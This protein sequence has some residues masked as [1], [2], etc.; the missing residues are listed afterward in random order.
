MPAAVIA[1]A[2]NGLYTGVTG[3]GDDVGVQGHS[4]SGTGVTA[5]TSTGIAL[6]VTAETSS[7]TAL[8]V[9]GKA[10]FD[11][12]GESGQ[13]IILSPTSH[14]TVPS[15]PSGAASVKV[16]D[17]RITTKSFISVVFVSDPGNGTA[18]RAAV[19]YI[20]RATGSFTVFLSQKVTKKTNFA[21]F[22]VELCPPGVA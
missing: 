13:T 16:L 15:I 4:D 19:S 12:G 9:V 22:F 2:T 10:C 14:F 17:P 20:A 18:G 6:Q 3:V 5:T 8:E 1:A 7:G 21:Y 11:N